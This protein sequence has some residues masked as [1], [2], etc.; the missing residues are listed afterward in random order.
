MVE[1]KILRYHVFSDGYDEWYS[2]DEY[3]KAV[4]DFYRLIKDGYTRVRIYEGFEN[5]ED[6]NPT[7]DFEDGDCLKSYGDFPS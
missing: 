3:D 7:G 5:Y 1:T 2:K 6:G 4:A